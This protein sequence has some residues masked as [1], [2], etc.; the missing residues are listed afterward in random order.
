M[1]HFRL[2]AL[3]ALLLPSL[4]QAHIWVG[5]FTYYSLPVSWTGHGHTDMVEATRYGDDLRG[6]GSWDRL[7]GMGGMDIIRGGE[8]DDALYGNRG[9]DILYGGKGDDFLDGGRGED[10]C[11]GGPGIDIYKNCEHTG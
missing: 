6:G 8:G 11:Y 9:S 1:T 7:K 3:L 4:A 5:D 2:A 10:W